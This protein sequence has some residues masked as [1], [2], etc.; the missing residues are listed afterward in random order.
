MLIDYI[1]VMPDKDDGH[2]RGRKY[3]FITNETDLIHS[4]ALIAK[5]NMEIY[6]HYKLELP[7]EI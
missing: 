7:L 3:P 5:G 1:T 2:N 6:Q 4:S